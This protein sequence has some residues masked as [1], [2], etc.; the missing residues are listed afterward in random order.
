[1]T[2][3]LYISNKG[4][5][6]KKDLYK[7]SRNRKDAVRWAKGKSA[8]LEDPAL[9]ASER[10]NAREVAKK[11]LAYKTL[12]YDLRDEATYT[13][14]ACTPFDLD[15]SPVSIKFFRL[16]LKT[17]YKTIDAL[18]KEWETSFSGWNKV[19]PLTTDEIQKRAFKNQKK[20]RW[21]Y[22]SGEYQSRSLGRSQRI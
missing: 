15:F 13:T 2:N 14:G 18:N 22:S 16:W 12:A 1:M 17:K 11:A 5:K 20:N 3:L 4:G 9:D 10:K 19:L 21:L 8:S 7:K 6:K